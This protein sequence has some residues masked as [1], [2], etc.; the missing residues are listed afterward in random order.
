M[1]NT[2]KKILNAARN[3]FLSESMMYIVIWAVC[4]FVCCT[5]FPES[6][7][8]SVSIEVAIIVLLK[9]I[10]DVKECVKHNS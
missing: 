4:T 3:T 1:R 9:A 7:Y 5:I 8:S 2:I 10:L 6:D